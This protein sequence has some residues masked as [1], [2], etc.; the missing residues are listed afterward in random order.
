MTSV[1][2]PWD[3]RGWDLEPEK[4]FWKNPLESIHRDP[5]SRTRTQSNKVE[6][7]R[8]ATIFFC[9]TLWLCS[10]LF[11]CVRLCL[12]STMFNGY[13]FYHFWTWSNTVKHG[14]TQ[15]N[16]VEHSHKVELQQFFLFDFCLTLFGLIR[17]CSTLFDFVRLCSGST[18]GILVLP[19]RWMLEF[20][21]RFENLQLWKLENQMIMWNGLHI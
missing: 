8:T 10:T 19:L 4:V 14:R 9:S 12:C 7:S 5:C 6:Q 15:S 13:Y 1:V 2:D 18:A 3:L 17:L 20:V 16:Q 11:D 21:I